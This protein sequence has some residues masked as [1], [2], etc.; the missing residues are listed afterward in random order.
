[1]NEDLSSIFEKLNINKDSISPDMVNN[2]MGMLSNNSNNTTSSNNETSSTPDIDIDT[3]LKMKSII[4][5][6]NTKTDDP[7]SKL[8]QSLR[9]YLRET[10]KSKLDQYMQLMNMSKIMD[11]LP[12]IGG[13]S[14]GTK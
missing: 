2:L 3:M 8:L 9:P 6:M 13:D 1:M 12:F 11:I 14:N 7:R 10:R 4:D 5:R